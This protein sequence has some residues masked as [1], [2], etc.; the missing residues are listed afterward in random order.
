ML[1]FFLSI[2]CRYWYSQK[3]VL[4]FHQ[5]FKKCRYVDNQ[6]RYFIIKTWKKLNFLLKK[7]NFSL[8]MSLSILISIS[9]FSEIP[10]WYRYFQE[11]PH[12][13]RYRYFQKCPYQY[14]YFQ[15]RPYRYRY[16]YFQ[17]WSYRYRYRYFQKCRYIDNRYGLSNTPSQVSN[18][19]RK[20]VAY[21][22]ENLKT[23]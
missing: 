15:E 10:I 19:S 17:E 4:I 7:M 8:K 2:F 12:W 21:F 6:Y 11:C 3:K 9:I 13:Y 16:R 23:P 14:R 22:H 1:T 18:L 5:Y 20:P